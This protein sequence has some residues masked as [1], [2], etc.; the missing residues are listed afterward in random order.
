MEYNQGPYAYAPAAQTVLRQETSLGWEAGL[1]LASV[2]GWQLEVGVFDQQVEDAIYFDLSAYSGYLQDT[3]A[4]DS[5]GV[6]LAASLPLLDTLRISGNLTFNETS[7]PNGQPRI[8]RPRRQANLGLNY[9]SPSGQLQVH[10][11]VRAAWDAV[12]EVFGLPD[13]VVLDDYAVLDVSAIYRIGERLEL[14]AR[15]EN[16]LDENYREIADYNSPGRAAYLG[17]RLHY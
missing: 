6:E 13:P 11:F 1:E 9:A 4:S 17:I 8:Q 5:R 14:V 10:G 2:D 12:D 3:G 15:L 7:R 16:A